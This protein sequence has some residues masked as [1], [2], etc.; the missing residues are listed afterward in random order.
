VWGLL[1]RSAQ[2][3]VAVVVVVYA[4]WVVS[5][6][7]TLLT[8][9]AISPLKSTSLVSTIISI[10]VIGGFGV[11]WRWLWRQIPVLSR[12]FP[13]L[14]GRWEGTYISSYRH[15]N[16]DQA[17]GSFAAVIRQGL[18]TSTVTAWTGEMRS[19]S[20]RSWLEADR[21]AQR[22]TVGY[23]YRSVPNAAVRDR[24][25]PHDGVCLLSLHADNDANRLTGIYYTERRTIG[26]LTL[27]RVSREPSKNT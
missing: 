21:D 15:A 13:D 16:G 23:T 10:V 6:V 24:S 19:N 1:P 11:C 3:G 26:D 7:S 4:A 27:R 5:E 14:T 12:W 25:T 2:I 9:P 18:F 8:G 22:F 17:T 20:T